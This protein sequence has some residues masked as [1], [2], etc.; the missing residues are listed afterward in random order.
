M[1]TAG[2]ILLTTSFSNPLTHWLVAK[3][4]NEFVYH[5]ANRAWITEGK[6]R[7]HN[8]TAKLDFDTT[9]QLL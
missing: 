8:R 5:Q 1:Q 3:L 7:Q 9:L 6:K 2:W 4:S